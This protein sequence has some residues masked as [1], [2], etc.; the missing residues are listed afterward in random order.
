MFLNIKLSPFFP[1]IT[2]LFLLNPLCAA[3]VTPLALSHTV[4]NQNAAILLYSVIKLAK[5][6]ADTQE[7]DDLY[8]ELRRAE[9]GAFAYGIINIVASFIEQQPVQ[10]SP[11]DSATDATGYVATYWLVRK[12]YKAITETDTALKIKERLALD[13]IPETYTNACKQIIIGLASY[14][15]YTWSKSMDTSLA[16]LTI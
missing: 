1:L 15:I 5:K 7:L 11:L 2:I 6:G 16:P 8:S 10:G 13:S 14:L 9:K 3:E 4:S 12:A